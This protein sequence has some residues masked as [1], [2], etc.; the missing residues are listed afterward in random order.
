MPATRITREEAE[1]EIAEIQ[2]W[3]ERLREQID[4][5]PQ[6]HPDRERKIDALFYG[7]DRIEE[8]KRLLGY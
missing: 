8:I 3:Q 2:E 1:R 5:L 7:H 6:H 4:A